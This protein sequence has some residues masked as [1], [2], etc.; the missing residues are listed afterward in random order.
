MPGWVLVVGWVGVMV[1]VRFQGGS[2]W[3]RWGWTGFGCCWRRLVCGCVGGWLVMGG[4]ISV[5]FVW[6]LGVLGRYLVF[7]V[8]W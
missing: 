7:G 2:V 6:N 8:E 3:F 1:V 4:G 5:V